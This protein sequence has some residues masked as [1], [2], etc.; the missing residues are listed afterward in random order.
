[1]ASKSPVLSI[2]DK[3]TIN[4][5]HGENKESVTLIW[6]DPNIGPRKDT[7]QT[8]QQLRLIN[9]YVIFSNDLEQCIALIESIDK[10]KIFLITSGSKASQILPRTSYFHQI[11]SIFIFC[12]NKYRYEYLLNKY[13]KIIG[14][15]I[16]LNDLCKSIKEQIDCVS[17]QIQTFS[18]FDQHQKSTKD[19]SK[20]SA[21]F[22]W[23]QLF[24]YIITRL[25]RNQQAKQQ[26]I[27]IC[28]EYYRGNT[29]EM[30]LIHEFEQNYRSED[31]ICWYSKQ[32]FLYKLINKALRTEDIDLLYK[33]RFFIGDLS[34]NLQRL[35]EKILLSEEKLLNVYRGVKL[36]KEEFIKLKENQG[37]LISINGY[38]STSRRKS[39]ALNF[40]MKP[41]K[42]IDVFP[43]LF[44]IHCDIKHID[45]NIIFADI[46]QFSQYPDEQE[47]LFDLNACFQIESIEEHESL[48][49][50]KLN[51]SNEGQ[52]ITKDYIKLTEQETEELSVSIV[53][54]RL[55]CNLGEYDKSQ[56]YFQQLLNDSNNED[57]AWIEFNIGRALAFKG[58]WHEARKYYD[59]AYNR[60][61]TSKPAR[62]K[63]SAHVLNNI[64]VILDKQGKYNEAL[65]YYQ[66]ALKIREKFYPVGHLDI[67]TSL[68]NIGLVL[69][70]QI[71]YDEAL[72]YH[73]RALKIREK[74]YPV[75]HVDIATSLNNIGN[76]LCNQGKYDEALKY[77][78]RALNIDQKFHPS[79][80][81][82]I[83]Y[84]LN[85]IGLVLSCQGKYDEALKY[86]QQALKIREKFYP[87]VHVDIATSLNNIG[88]ILYNQGNYDE[89]LNYH[90]RA[91][92]IREKYYPS[93]HVDIATSLNNIGLIVYYQGKYNEALDYHQ[94]ALKIQ[95][96]F[97]PSD[98]LDMATS[99]HNIG[100]ILNRQGK[101]DEALDYYQRALKI[102]EKFYPSGH[103][104]I[105]TSLHN[106]GK[107]LNRQEK[108][109]KALDYYQRAL[110]MRKKCYPSGHV[111]IADSLNNI[112]IC[113]EN[114]NKQKMAL[115]YYQH[116][117]AIYE[118]FLLAEHPR[119][120]RTENIIRRLSKK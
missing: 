77:Y 16:S 80:H 38:L 14:I 96:K 115:D 35:H 36:D 111:N 118:K 97:Y 45:K 18:F 4:I 90:Q 56:K 113:Y 69:S 103:I 29:K 91:L 39:L 78:Q 37:N 31:A 87:S 120:Q 79:G 88:V 19:L 116:A 112:G 85:N 48:Q 57:H 41:T 24:H 50:I 42:R 44:H 7:E 11:D 114:K 104:D 1:M 22:L 40:A 32:S 106:I 61:M 15:Y 23:F 10:E 92:K 107:I 100:R 117:L 86:H 58:E 65:D 13:S 30:K 63:D 54:G 95:E 27:Q 99:L 46:H 74:F 66:R 70:D 101:Y 84:S 12:M 89:A 47:V 3:Q 26:M 17:R 34:E 83:A 59:R 75:D 9:D 110:K 6:F 102:R 52:Q 8:K 53:F 81:A 68:N 94:R 20:E 73:Q 28:K 108:Y 21:E 64:G 55:L 67:A 71:R 5:C 62:I 49:I 93:G 25:P 109:D 98:H 51:L 72:D 105:A 2:E 119:R 33:F 76:I 60:M 82:D 43:V